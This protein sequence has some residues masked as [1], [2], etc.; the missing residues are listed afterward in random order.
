MQW[1]Q[2]CDKIVNGLREEDDDQ[3]VKLHYIF[4]SKYFYFPIYKDFSLSF[5]SG[6]QLYFS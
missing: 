3:E 1:I 6:L 5:L 2:T 4:Y